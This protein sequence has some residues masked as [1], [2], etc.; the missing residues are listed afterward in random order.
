MKIPT[1]IINNVQSLYDRGFYCQAYQAAIE[2]APLA[3]WT[4]TDGRILAGRVALQVGGH[5]L[6]YNHHLRAWRQDRT[7]MRAALYYAYTLLNRGGL[8]KAWEFVKSIEVKPEATPREKSEWWS[9][10][11]C[12]L[13]EF[14]D[15]DT[16]NSW[17][18][19]AIE[20]DPENYWL[21]ITQSSYWEKQDLYLEALTAATKALE[22]K[23]NNSAAIT[24]IA[25]MLTLLERDNEALE[26]LKSAAHNSE[27]CSIIYALAQLQT[28]LG[29]Y[30]GAL[31]SYQ[32][33]AATTPLLEPIFQQWL[34]S[35]QA[36][37]AYSLGDFDG[38]IQLAAQVKSPF[39]QKFVDRLSTKP[40]Q[41]KRVLLP[42]GFVRQHQATCA[43][44][45][46]ATL[47]RFWAKPVEHLTIAAEIC[48]DGTQAHRERLWAEKNGW[49]ASEFTITWESAV[50]LLDRGI[51]FA[52]TTVEPSSAHLQAIIG[53]DSYLK[54]FLI[55]DPYERQLGE[56]WAEETLL[57]YASSGPR[58]MLML[59]SEHAALLVDIDL[60]DVHLYDLSHQIHVA[61]ENNQRE[62]AGQIYRQMQDLAPSHRLTLDV[63][64][65]ISGYDGDETRVLAAIEKMLL[66]FPNCSNLLLQKLLCL[67]ELTRREER[68]ELLAN[69]CRS[70][71]HPVFWQSYAQELSDDGR[72]APAA[73]ALLKKTIRWMPSSA[74][75]YYLLARTLWLQRKYDISFELY[76]FATCLEDKQGRYARV[77]F[78]TARHR[79]QTSVA[80]Q[81]LENRYQRF[82]HKSSEPVLTLF[83]AYSQ[84]NRMTEAFA[85]LERACAEQE[86]HAGQNHQIPG[87]LMI[88]AANAYA[89]YGQ[90]QQSASL[91]AKTRELVA[92]VTWLRIAAELAA[93]QGDILGSLA[94]LQAIL[95]ITP[96]EI[97]VNRSVANLLAETQGVDATLE[98]LK[99][100]CDRFPS[101]Y[102]LHQ[103][104]CSWLESEDLVQAEQVLRHLVEIDPC[105]GWT[106]R[107]LALVLGKQKKLNDAFLEIYA[108]RQHDPH[109]SS[110]RIIYA[111]LCEQSADIPEAKKAYQ[112]ALKLSIDND[113]AINSW[114]ALCYTAEERQAALEFIFNELKEQ[115]TFGDALITYQQQAVRHLSPEKLLAQMKEAWTQRPD[116]WQSWSVLVLQLLQFEQ[117]D[118]ALEL[119]LSYTEQ[120]PL[121][122]KAWLDLSTVYRE[123]KDTEN[124]VIALQRS[125]AIDQ[126]WSVPIGRLSMI[127]EQTKQFDLGK[128]FLEAA[129][130]REPRRFSYHCHLAEIFWH[131]NERSA[132]LERLKIVVQKTSEG[133]NYAWAWEKLKEWSS[134]CGC[135]EFAIELV[136]E[137]TKTRGSE[138][139]SWYFLADVLSEG[140]DYPERLAA[141]D[142][143]IKLDIYYIDAYDLKARLLTHLQEY[144]AA[145]NV[146]NTTAWLT[147]RPISL[148]A[149]VVWIEQQWGKHQEALNHLKEM[150][151][152]EPGYEWAWIQLA[153]YYDNLDRLPEYLAA[154][155]K[156][157]E[158]DPRDPVYWGYLGDAQN[159][160]G[161]KSAAQAA[162]GKS[163][164][165]H[166]GYSYG[167]LSLFELYWQAQDFYAATSVFA[168]IQPHLE[169]STALPI[170]IRIAVYYHDQ[171]VAESAL[172]KLCG[173]DVDS[174]DPVRT[175]IEGMRLEGWNS[176]ITKIIDQQLS[177]PMVGNWV[178]IF[179]AEI[180]CESNQWPKVEK[181][182]KTLDFSVG[183]NQQCISTYLYSLA[184]NHQKKT[185][186]SF[187]SQHY[188]L[189]KKETML[190]G[191]VGHALRMI[192]DDQAV[193]KWM[194][195]WRHRS[196]V[197]AWMV[198]NLAESLRGVGRVAEAQVINQYALKL[199]TNTGQRYH[200]C[201]LAFDAACAG[202]IDHANGLLQTL[203][204]VSDHSPEYQFLLEITQALIAANAVM[205]SHRI[206]LKIIYRHLATA[207][208]IY[209]QFLPDAPY[210]RA[211]LQSLQKLVG[212]T[213][214]WP[215]FQKWVQEMFIF[216]RQIFTFQSAN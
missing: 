47:T 178:K 210:Y 166:P 132:A 177:A 99:N 133:H 161:D 10:R 78:Q 100:I 105:D 136:R 42:V 51:P 39:W 112:A 208:S 66:Q 81:L 59:P 143:A 169:P 49:I 8:L 127:Y 114:L 58:G 203:L 200:L 24:S 35:K 102:S 41:G 4:D 48:Y 68:L 120:F 201:W 16:A 12:L 162:W 211:Y 163:I 181:Y 126:T 138:A 148:R 80:L 142:R 151:V 6:G 134:I 149:R 174:L 111:Y 147:D 79:K 113:N 33:Y 25:R 44:A 197:G 141:L 56:M 20:L 89:E 7:S 152:I 155:Q 9:L 43:P 77:Y 196:D 185:L 135:P 165:I 194:A 116:L 76:R 83:W 214:D 74:N 88:A 37:L 157:V 90:Y 69:I 1:V 107:Q 144:E 158:L 153:N 45:T 205:G 119:A 206:K 27:S 123:R 207:K 213:L 122:A 96:L 137:L 173:C 121:L 182:I 198:G 150:I 199:P 34:L 50:A 72:A 216:Y 17:L 61:I 2:H 202:K 64:R 55:R 209:P 125:L 106:R 188:K 91:L 212:L 183:L 31:Q 186:R 95:A 164:E 70:N 139:T 115:V 129:I 154:V 3:E 93:K 204:P 179:W 73:I 86:N 189:L 54:Q 171:V 32:Q 172:T 110:E 130:L 168:K 131:L 190:W 117:P 104:W 176:S 57:H 87:D 146:C 94:H 85:L 40:L 11:A 38:A 140:K 180:A 19:K 53:Y 170:E 13:I 145:I 159:R 124:E 29:D 46:M 167:G 52:L 187:I 36:D 21:Y 109:S 103:L 98:F 97:E 15:F 101:S 23:P 195:D 62:I 60:P 14:R 156:L 160:L 18:Q 118:E 26:L 192:N 191:I 71:P 175:A 184:N 92:P 215:L 193:I 128:E 5:R 22:F 84:L 75:N 30:R 63:E 65:L 108:A 82:G 67:R 28:E